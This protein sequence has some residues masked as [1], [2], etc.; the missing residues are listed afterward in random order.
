M[1]PEQRTLRAKIAAHSLHAQGKTNTA[2]ASAGL[3]AK[4][5]RDADPDG[6]LSPAERAVRAAHLRTVH[7]LRLSAAGAEARRRSRS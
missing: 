1:T 7:F 4:F 3:E 2:A 5:L 6:T